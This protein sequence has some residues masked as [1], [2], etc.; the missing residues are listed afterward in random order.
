M[1]QGILLLSKD[2]FYAN[3]VGKL[4]ERPIGDKD[5]ITELIR[6]KTV[7]CSYNTLK[8]LPNSMF[9][10]ASF[11][12][13]INANYDINFGIETFRTARPDQLI[14]IRS[15]ETMIIGKQYNLKDWKLIFSS[16]DFEMYV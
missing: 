11:T 13:N 15:K 4:P 7:L 8:E 6:G 12:T 3:V 10:I 14:V 2:G 5:F 1:T 16:K 9:A